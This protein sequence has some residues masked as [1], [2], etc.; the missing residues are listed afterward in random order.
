MDGNI[1]AI[2]LYMDARMSNRGYGIKHQIAD[3]S[4]DALSKEKT[5]LEN[6]YLR[7]VQQQQLVFDAK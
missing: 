5:Q 6:S 7:K 4:G 1:S 2:K 3:S